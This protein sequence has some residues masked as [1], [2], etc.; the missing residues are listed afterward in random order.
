MKVTIDALRDELYSEM[1]EYWPE[2][3]FA[4][5]L[6]QFSIRSSMHT[7]TRTPASPLEN[8]ALAFSC[9]TY[10]FSPNTVSIFLG[11]LSCGVFPEGSLADTRGKE[12][13][14]FSHMS[15][16]RSK[17]GAALKSVLRPGPN[18]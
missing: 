15:D 18:T 17:S 14:Y 4:T 2:Q 13:V 16:G 1:L 12:G 10:G 5:L 9:C 6:H 11:G 8:S 3:Q 7:N